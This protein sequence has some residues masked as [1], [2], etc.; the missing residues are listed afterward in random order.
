MTV[1]EILEIDINYVASRHGNNRF[2]STIK[3]GYQT[4]GKDFSPRNRLNDSFRNNRGWNS[5]RGDNQKFRNINKY[6]HHAR[7]PKNN[8]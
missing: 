5:P 7:E 6:K 4:D 2:N 8:N 3:T 1:N